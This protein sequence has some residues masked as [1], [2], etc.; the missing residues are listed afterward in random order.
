MV[1][2]MPPKPD[3]Y[4]REIARET[5]YASLKRARK[6]F[7]KHNEEVAIPVC[8]VYFLLICLLLI[9]LLFLSR[10]FE[11]CSSSHLHR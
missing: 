8:I 9:C 4:E 7:K 10:C 5:E 11:V 6:D 2:P 1:G 3:Q